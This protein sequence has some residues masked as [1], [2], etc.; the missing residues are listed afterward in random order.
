MLDFD[1]NQYCYGCGVCANS[2]PNGAIK[3]EANKDG[4]LVPKIDNAKCVHC[5]LCDKN[6]IY[7]NSISVK[8]LCPIEES[9][10]KMVYLKSEEILKSASGGAFY[11]IAKHALEQGYYVC[12][13]IW[14]ENFE[15]VHTVTKNLETV[16]KMRGSKY[17]QS[18][19]GD[20]YR[21]IKQLI[22][23]GEKVLFSGTPCQ[24][25]ALHKMVGQ[26]ESLIS[27]GL[28]CEGVPS[29]KVFACW[30]NHLEKKEHSK[31]NGIE[32]RKKGRYGWKSPS[33]LYC[34]ENGKKS[35]QLAFHMD[36]YMYNFLQGTFMRESCSHCSYKGDGITADIVLG[37]C[38]SASLDTIH[39]NKNRGLSVLIIRTGKGQKLFEEIKPSFV[40][41][42][43]PVE[44][45][46]V[47]NRPLM[48]SNPKNSR[49]DLFFSYFENHDLMESIKK[50]G[51]YKTP[52]LKI[53]SLLY[54]MHLFGFAKKMLKKN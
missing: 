43:V 32:L 22:D 51:Y 8:S 6:C 45:V 16:K 25:A 36:M 18:N 26:S 44:E 3:M 23:H 53:F 49:R 21:K 15:V 2:C 31:I 30:L 48:T 47:K 24:V 19:M 13:A 5:G 14:N 42:D 9:D 33:S 37:D 40:Y 1:L 54:H 29:P 38:W 17:V 34:F 20:V 27:I 52:K 50:Y 4:F 35:E 10:C 39:A 46:V 12:G 41:E 11:G 28:I 7:L